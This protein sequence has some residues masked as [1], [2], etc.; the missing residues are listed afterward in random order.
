ML[1]EYDRGDDL[2]REGIINAVINFTTRHTLQ[3]YM[4]KYIYK[5]LSSSLAHSPALRSTQYNKTYPQFQE[6][7]SYVYFH[8]F[9]CTLLYPIMHVC[10]K[11]D[12]S[13]DSFTLACNFELFY[14]RF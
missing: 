5:N 14:Y 3:K 13:N 8:I 9:A 1:N 12:F 2:S 11:L 10:S 4:L 7:R 6:E